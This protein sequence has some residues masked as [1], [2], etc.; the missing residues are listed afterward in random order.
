[1]RPSFES[2]L[3][4]GPAPLGGVVIAG[5]PASDARLVLSAALRSAGYRLRLADS[6]DDLLREA[7]A[8]DVNLAIIDVDLACP[9]GRSAIEALK[10]TYS[11][12][13]IP[14]LAFGGASAGI[15]EARAVA[16][17]ADRFLRNPADLATLFHVVA[18]MRARAGKRRDG[19]SVR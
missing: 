10:S 11:P 2:R 18:S 8:D 6:G 12:R 5:D 3:T 15:P 7:M 4:Q 1:M 17:G 19:A 16:A 14:I 13:A 9:D